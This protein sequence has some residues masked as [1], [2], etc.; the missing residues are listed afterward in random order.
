MLI[1]SFDWWKQGDEPCDADNVH[2]QSYDG[3]KIGDNCDAVTIHFIGRC[4]VGESEKTLGD[5]H[6]FGELQ[7]VDSI[8]E[9]IHHREP[10]DVFGDI[11]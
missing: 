1:D 7:S 4:D 2:E 3:F 6:G 11:D 8:D 9:K 10:H 5:D